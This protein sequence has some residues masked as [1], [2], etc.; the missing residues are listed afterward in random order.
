MVW[1]SGFLLFWINV[2]LQFNYLYI[3]LKIKYSSIIM[4]LAQDSNNFQKVLNF[5]R[6]KNR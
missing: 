2:K 3:K 5:E 6:I 1:N 4:C